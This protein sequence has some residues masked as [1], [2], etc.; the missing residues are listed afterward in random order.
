MTSTSSIDYTIQAL[1]RALEVLEAFISTDR[2]ALSVT[3]ISERL[4]LNKSRVFRILYTFEQ[5]HFVEQDPVSKQYHLGL[6]LMVLSEAVRRGLDLVAIADPI[7]DEL[8]EQSGETIHLNVLDD[9]QAICVAK[10]E[11]KYSVRLHAEIGKA[12]PLYAGGASKVLLAYLPVEE[13]NQILLVKDLVPITDRTI[14][15]PEQLE[16]ALARIRRDGYA[17]S[18][19]ELDPGAHS[20]AAPIR[21]K[22]DRVMAAISI[23]G[24]SHRF[25]DD[26]IQLFSRLVCRAA[27]QISRQLGYCS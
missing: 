13:Q 12:M 15:D 27:L 3:D 6:Q 21:D 26:K 9:C 14:T 2:S 22:T 5:H 24:P 7:M 25:S 18:I 11:S 16:E 20:V 23:A 19:G 4:G 17:V 10:R 8:V 1:H